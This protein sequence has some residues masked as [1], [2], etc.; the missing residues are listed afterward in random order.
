MK[1]RSLLLIL[2]PALL[3]VGCAQSAISNPGQTPEAA[4]PTPEAI[5]YTPEPATPEPDDSDAEDTLVSPMQ[6][7]G[8][9]NHGFFYIPDVWVEF[10]ELDAHPDDNMIQFSDITGTNI[11][12]VRYVSAIDAPSLETIANNSAAYME[13][14]GA[15][16]VHGATVELNGI[17]SLQVYGFWPDRTAQVTW[18]FEYGENIHIISAEGP[19]ETIFQTVS[20]LES[21]FSFEP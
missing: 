6:R 21:S 18:I 20:F 11:I 14:I 12:T 7:V 16:E 19:F 2:L 15:E 4:T 17:D 9:E 3:L 8:N 5:I 13:N 10:R 1:K